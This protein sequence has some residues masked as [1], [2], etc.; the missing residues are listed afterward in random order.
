[1]SL[2]LIPWQQW[3]YFYFCL[4][5]IVTL[6]PL[7]TAV[8]SLHHLV[9]TGFVRQS[10]IRLRIS[11]K[12]LCHSDTREGWEVRLKKTDWISVGWPLK[13]DIL[14]GLEDT[15][16]PGGEGKQVVVAAACS[17]VWHTEVCLF[18]AVDPG[19]S[20]P[21]ARDQIEMETCSMCCVLEG[22]SL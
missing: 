9:L 22:Q 10:V 1:M 20:W 16:L 18:F 14:T 6:G 5:L 7:V 13:Q 11:F 3:R 19:E 21:C 2:F 8:S 17:C 15:R 12:G 4:V